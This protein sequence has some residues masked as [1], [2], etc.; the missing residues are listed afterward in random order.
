MWCWA[1]CFGPEG[2]S[3][4]TTNEAIEGWLTAQQ[5]YTVLGL[6]R[7]TFYARLKGMY[8]GKIRTMQAGSWKL[9]SAE[10]VES[11]RREP[12]AW[13]LRREVDPLWM[14]SGEA[15]K[16]LGVSVNTLKAQVASGK[17]QVGH[18]YNRVGWLM[19]SRADIEEQ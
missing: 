9:Y 16:A 19:V 2:I 6:T 13:K 1:R 7:G 18:K 8:A 10:D 3:P 15:A 12:P 5:A 11:L 4:M 14:T 17:C